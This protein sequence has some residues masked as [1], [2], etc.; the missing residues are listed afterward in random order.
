ML[1]RTRLWLASLLKRRQF[2]RDVADELA[3][4]RQARA[5]H[6]RR[7]GV[8]ASEAERRARVEFGSLD[9]YQEAVRDV[10][11]GAW[12]V[13][14]RQDLRYAV[15]VLLNRPGFAAATILT[16]ALGI[17][18][19]ATVFSLLDVV[20]LRPL[21]VRN[22]DELAHIYDSCRRGDVY[23]QMSYPEY[24]DYRSQSRT[25]IDMAAFH[26]VDVNVSADSGSWIGSGLLVSTN[27]FSLL[28]IA[29]HVGQLFSPGWNVRGDPP[30][31]LSHGVWLMRFGGDPTVVGGTIR[32][33]GSSF[34][35]VGVA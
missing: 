1:T 34:R 17:G 11:T 23:C 25:F 18:A 21:P 35:I 8:P 33:S 29:P 20:L 30:V 19:T 2:D 14:L 7:E 16:L 27:Y 3:F 9:K 28:G 6:L 26:P 15:R 24:L 5:E 4:H 31:V 32:L 12:V 10:R 13:Q 22:P